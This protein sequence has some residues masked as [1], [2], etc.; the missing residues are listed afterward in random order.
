MGLHLFRTHPL[1]NGNSIPSELPAHLLTLILATT[2]ILGVFLHI[3]HRRARKHLLL[4]APPGSIASVVALTSHS[5]FGKRLRPYDDELIMEKK[6]DGLRFGLDGHTGAIVA[7]DHVTEGAMEDEG[8]PLRGNGVGVGNIEHP[9]VESSSQLALLMAA[10]M[11]AEL[12]WQRSW[13]PPGMSP[14]Q[15]YSNTEYEP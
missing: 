3:I 13:E 15:Q 4:A 2:G 10:E 8:M 5:D 9:G 12:P 1:S 11:A 14:L 6:L 7:D